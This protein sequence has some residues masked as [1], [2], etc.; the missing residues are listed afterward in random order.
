MKKK[1][2]K[3]LKKNQMGHQGDVLLI[4]VDSIPED[5][6]KLEKPILAYGK[7]T[8]HKHEILDDKSVEY[9]ESDGKD[10]FVV[11][12]M[13]VIDKI[14]ANLVHEDHEG[15]NLQ[16]QFYP[17]RNQNEIVVNEEDEEIFQRVID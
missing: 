16:H 11:G 2:T 1:V 6:K 4:P 14:N 7:I 13:R 15:I 12:W 5:L 9:Y 10:P 3:V 8:G 17:I